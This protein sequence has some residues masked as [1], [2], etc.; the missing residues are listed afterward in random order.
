[1]VLSPLKYFVDKTTPDI[2]NLGN[3]VVQDM[4][5]K[6]TKDGRTIIEIDFDEILK[7]FIEFIEQG[8]ERIENFNGIYNKELYNMAL[9]VSYKANDMYESY[10]QFRDMVTEADNP[11]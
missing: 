7:D 10:I 4:E 1:M 3:N 11:F 9:E 8:V 2:T 6:F 5:A